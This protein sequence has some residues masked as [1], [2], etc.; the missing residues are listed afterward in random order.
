M[1]G[2]ALL[3]PEDPDIRRL[4]EQ[5]RALTEGAAEQMEKMRES[6]KAFLQPPTEL[7]PMKDYPKLTRE[8]LGEA[9]EN[10]AEIVKRITARS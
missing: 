10:N 4:T 1:V 2:G 5:L 3:R 7:E 9:F 8:K 6:V